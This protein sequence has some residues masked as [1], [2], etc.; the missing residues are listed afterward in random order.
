MPSVWDHISPG[1]ICREVASL[2]DPPDNIEARE[3][4]L[5]ELSAV[6]LVV[7]MNQKYVVLQ[8]DCNSAS[9]FIP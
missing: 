8:R 1:V 9:K 2:R 5:G 3:M 7:T 4:G 6:G